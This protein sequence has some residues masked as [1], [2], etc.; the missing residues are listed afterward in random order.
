MEPKVI[1]FILLCWGYFGKFKN[2]QESLS[3]ININ[4]VE[5]GNGE[6]EKLKVILTVGDN[7]QVV[8]EKYRMDIYD[9]CIPEMIKTNCLRYLKWKSLLIFE[10]FERLI[11]WLNKD[12]HLSKTIK[13]VRVLGC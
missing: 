7:E 5:L 6:Y 8:L 13:G 3:Q 11:N 4:E 2:I 1:V 9:D 10:E 12:H